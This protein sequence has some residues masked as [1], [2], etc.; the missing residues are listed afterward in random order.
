MPQ[1]AAQ[2]LRYEVAVPGDASVLVVE[3]AVPAGLPPYF[4]MARGAVPFVRELHVT[5][6]GERWSAMPGDKTGTDPRDPAT[7]REDATVRFPSPVEIRYVRVHISGFG[8]LPAWHIGA[9]ELAWIFVDE[10]EVR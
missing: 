6:D 5:T 2:G 7:T 1:N 9:G 4:G 10:I 3:A 8:T